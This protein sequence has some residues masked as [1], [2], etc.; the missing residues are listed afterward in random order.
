MAKDS[1]RRAGT[2][3]TEKT[4]GLLSGLLAEENEFDRR[5]LWR[6]GSWGVLALGGIIVAV[7]ANQYSIGLR[8]EQYAAADLLR[9]AQQIQTLARDSQI[10]ARRLASAVETL[11]GDR[12]RLYSRVTMLE[13]GLDSV[14]GAITRQNGGSAAASPGKPGAAMAMASPGPAADAAPA[15]Q[16]PI[17]A[18]VATTA[19][20]VADRPKVDAPRAEQPRELIKPDSSKPESVKPESLKPEP[21]AAAPT[22]SAAAQP[23]PAPAL[24]SA[25]SMMGPPDP[26]APKLV[27]ATRLASSSPQP[28]P[29]PDAAT[30]A[31]TRDMSRELFKDLPRDMSKESSKDVSK[32]PSRDLPKIQAKESLKESLKESAKDSPKEP[33][34]ESMKESAKDKDA[35]R[36]AAPPREADAQEV[37]APKVQR[38][39]FAVDLGGANS[40][41]GL[42]ALWRGL[43]KTNE[44]LAGL[45]PI[46]MVREGNTGLGM[47]LRLAAGPLTDAASAAR[48]CAALIESDRSCE[49]T[50]Y[51]GQ[52]L[53]MRASE[54]QAPATADKPQDTAKPASGYSYKRGASRQH[55]SR[56][57]EPAPKPEAPSTFSQFF[58]GSKR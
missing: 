6:V 55:S 35:P 38:T 43:V 44:D 12:D 54:G 49:T 57:D 46:I 37:A 11:N 19:A 10:E 28:Q 23:A 51:D 7:M 47:Q 36:E 53:A 1:D 52:R 22:G 5:T 41:G 15:Q 18:P 48:I 25:K 29:A 13:Q 9:Q 21:A 14:T 17:M 34:K 30:A 33:A 26:G 39:E 3:E 31:A 56:K 58:G 24:V 40:I 50:V 2:L 27:E 45:H 42:R 16:G 20:F 8:R 32:D 4:G